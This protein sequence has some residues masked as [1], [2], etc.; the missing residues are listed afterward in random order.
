MDAELITIE[1]IEE[2]N[3]INRYIRETRIEHFYWT[4]GTDQAKE[5]THIWFTN[6]QPINKDLWAKGQPD[7]ANKVENCHE[8]G[9]KVNN[10]L[11]L[12]DRPCNFANRYI[13][14]ARQP[15]T[16]SFVLW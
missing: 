5:G 12:N 8:L 16:A 14:E 1:T 7:N 2:W 11:G 4:S 3:E 9:W 10:V 13:C 15:V 6:G